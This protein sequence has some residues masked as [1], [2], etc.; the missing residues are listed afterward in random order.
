LTASSPPAFLTSTRLFSVN[1]P[2]T[3][4]LQIDT[5]AFAIRTSA[6][7]FTERSIEPD[8]I[9]FKG[10]RDSASQISRVSSATGTASSTRTNPRP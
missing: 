2:M 9:N 4:A 6:P 3:V 7:L 5:R 1:L 10:S 8:P